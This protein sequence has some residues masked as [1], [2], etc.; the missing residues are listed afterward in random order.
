MIRFGGT[1][2]HKGKRPVRKMRT[3][4]PDKTRSYAARATTRTRHVERNMK[5]FTVRDYIDW[6]EA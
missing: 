5:M 2:Q 1:V 6:V 3:L 4:H